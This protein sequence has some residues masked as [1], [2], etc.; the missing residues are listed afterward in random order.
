MVGYR[1]E[2]S[3]RWCGA[4]AAAS[5]LGAEMMRA[6]KVAAALKGCGV[7]SSGPVSHHLEWA[8]KEIEALAALVVADGLGGW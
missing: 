4:C 2:G 7:P 5:H 3:R 8:A 1:A 6:A